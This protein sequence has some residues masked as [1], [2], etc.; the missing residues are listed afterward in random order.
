MTSEEIKPGTTDSPEPPDPYRTL[1]FMILSPGVVSR[2]FI[3]GTQIGQ[4]NPRAIFVFFWVAISILASGERLAPDL[5]GQMNNQPY[6]FVVA[7]L[8]EKKMKDQKTNLKAFTERYTDAAKTNIRL[9]LVLLPLIFTLPLFLV[10]IKKKR[11]YSEHSLVAYEFFTLLMLWW[12]L[13]LAWIPE[14]LAKYVAIVASLVLLYMF[15]R[16]TYQESKSRSI[17]KAAMLT[18]LLLASIAIYRTGIFFITFWKL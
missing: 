10:N 11:K 16:N 5:Y 8:I 12:F 14:E 7:P 13:V 1:R 3:E 6:S 15:E 2:Q 4:V 17:S 9:L 18:V